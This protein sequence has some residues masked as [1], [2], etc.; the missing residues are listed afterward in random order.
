MEKAKRI[1][2]EVKGRVQMVMFRDFVQRKARKLELAGWVQNKADGS[3]AI[4]AE[5]VESAL[6]EFVR[7]LWR[8]PILAHVEDVV[9]SW[10][11]ATGEFGQFIIRY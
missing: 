7:L 2:C 4:V 1:E 10:K 5:G 3:V 11:D 6:Q 9:V 8:G